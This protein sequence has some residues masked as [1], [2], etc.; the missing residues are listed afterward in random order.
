[1]PRYAVF[2]GVLSAAGL[3]I[4]IHAPKFFVDTYG[5]SLSALATALFFLRLIDVVQD[6]FFGWL[7]EAARRFRGVLVA[8][9]GIVMAVSM[10]GLFAV[11][12]PIAPVWWFALTL[13]GLFSGFSLLTITFYTQGVLKA[14]MMGDGHVRLAMWRETGALA[15]V[16]LASVAPVALA[17]TGAPF[18]SYAGLF[19]ALTLLALWLMR[20]EW[21]SE[22]SSPAA[23]P[24]SQILRDATARRLL[25][26][27][28]L[29][30][31]PVAVTSTLFLFFVESRLEAPGME[32]PLLL[33]FFL[34][35]ALSAPLWG[36][37]AGRYGAKPML[38][39]GMVLAIVTFAFALT[40]G[41]GDTALFA[42]ICVASGATL[43]A[44]ITLLSALFA[45]HMA[46]IAPNA[47]NGFGLWSF[48]SKFTLA[49]AAIALLPVLQYSGFEAG[50][51]NPPEALTT[52]TI[53]YAGVPCALKLLALALL[54]ATR[55]TET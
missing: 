19:A 11:P 1:L 40:L 38:L 3:P 51:I 25:L 7:S 21:Q 47:G 53:L 49:I 31:A 41:A 54:A 6:P 14:D 42:V 52:L 17:V 18:M 9:G 8:L 32:G 46:K 10:W 45:R 44:D 43:G 4:Y 26:I 48:V 27:A 50:A 24:M 36:R 23:V 16:C 2:A 30:A 55:L 20:G 37:L 22:A 13:A 35:A 12:P 33:L 28:L 29:N 5:V 34:A 39:V 15:G